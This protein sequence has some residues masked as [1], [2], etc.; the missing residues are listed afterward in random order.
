MESLPWNRTLLVQR[1]ASLGEARRGDAVLGASCAVGRI[2]GVVITRRHATS[3]LVLPDYPV[4]AIDAQSVAA[5]MAWT[6]VRWHPPREPRFA[7]RRPVQGRSK[8]MQSASGAGSAPGAEWRVVTTVSVEVPPE[9]VVSA[10]AAAECR[11]VAHESSPRALVY[12]AAAL[13]PEL[14]VVDLRLVAL[15]T[16]RA[17]G[18]LSDAAPGIRIVAISGTPHPVVT[19]AMLRDGVWAH[20]GYR[21]VRKSLGPAL[22]AVRNG[23]LWSTRAHLTGLL[24]ALVASTS[25]SP[26]ARA[27][28]DAAVALSAD[29]L[30][31]RESAVMRLLLQGSCNKEI[32]RSLGISEQTV[33]IHLQHVYRKLGV[34]SRMQLFAHALESGR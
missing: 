10:A 27:R 22:R 3:E 30:T 2:L 9:A 18:A 28:P 5:A 12:V 23:E 1:H 8:N 24:R 34:S 32:A 29:S 21:D 31:L 16:A 19:P 13:R 14:A 17:L 15:G 7:R 20:L 11:L 4:R 33:K 25:G 26:G 6:P